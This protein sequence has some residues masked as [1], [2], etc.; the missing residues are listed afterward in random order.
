MPAKLVARF[1]LLAVHRDLWPEPVRCPDRLTRVRFDCRC[2]CVCV[3]VAARAGPN[4][5]G[6]FMR[7]TGGL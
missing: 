6:L 4:V 1:F 2:V 3:R 7:D 5:I